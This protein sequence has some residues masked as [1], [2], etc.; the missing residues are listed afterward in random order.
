[1]P[2]LWLFTV[3][4]KDC[5]ERINIGPAPS[6]AALSEPAHEAVEV[7][8]PYCSAIHAYPGEEVQRALVD[9]PAS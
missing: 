3:S 8:C 4:C 6:P 9:Q 2:L 7:G 5:G 1:M